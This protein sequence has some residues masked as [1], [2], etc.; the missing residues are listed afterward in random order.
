MR[1]AGWALALAVVSSSCAHFECNLHGGD[2][3]R[4]IKTEHFVVT[5][6][7][8]PEAH[9]AQAE[10]LELLW[11][12]FSVFFGADVERAEVPVVVL[13]SERA[14]ES[15]SSGYYS[16]FVRRQGP[17]VLVVGGAATAK[18][19]HDSNA[20]ELT[21]LVSAFL[22]P[23]QPRW[24]SE[25]LASLFENA[26]FKSVRTV[27]M[28]GWN[29]GRAEE[30]LQY[31]VLSLEELGEW[32]GL[33]FDSQETLF[34]ASAWA[35][36]RYLS[37]HEEAKL[38]R[39]FDGLRGPRPVP[40]LM[41]ELFPPAEA[42]R[43]HAAVKAYLSSARY[44]EW[45]TSLRRNPKIE[46]PVV[47]PPWEVHALRSRLYL[48]DEDAARKEQQAA[49]ALAPSPLPPRAAVL[50]AALE[51][52]DAKELLATYPAAG[53]VL[54]A[55]YGR[56]DKDLDDAKLQDALKGAD[57]DVELLL[58]AANTAFYGAEDVEQATRLADRGAALAPWS[59]EFAGLRVDIALHKKECA[60][61]DRR[62]AQ[63]AS[64][65]SERPQASERE[66]LAKLR[67]RVKAC[68]SP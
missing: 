24:L 62:V 44:R 6:D 19:A 50:K 36:V 5:S 32:G 59:V 14:V 27:T 12:T 25:G 28:G 61:A 53:P 57:A 39:L 43:L 13:R 21:H 31:G 1:I 10:R 55:A 58:L 22:L 11:D 48:R 60:E 34:Y 65:M 45:E 16:G 3:V 49:V 51:K 15:F 20:H 7:L 41:A 38:K 35:W 47:L 4:S 18:S 23:R 63:V 33:R 67:D 2:E 42:Q 9:R 37:N 56:F 8:P 52:R 64:L 68:A 54:V 66:Q 29:E 40:E 46:A 30:A 26:T 17:T